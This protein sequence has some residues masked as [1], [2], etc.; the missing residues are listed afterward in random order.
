MTQLSENKTTPIQAHLEKI[1]E[2]INEA[3]ILNYFDLQTVLDRGLQ[4][5][6]FCL[7]NRDFPA[8]SKQIPTNNTTA[9]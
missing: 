2:N 1:K 6:T 7:G 8:V 3:N 9:T 5:K 4:L